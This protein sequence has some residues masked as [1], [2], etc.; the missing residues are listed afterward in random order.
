M[1]KLKNKAAQ[2][3]NEEIVNR[4]KYLI[5]EESLT[6]NQFADYIGIDPSNL[7]KHLNG[8]LPINDSLINKIVVNIGVSKDW[9]K[10]G[11]D[12][13]YS[14]NAGEISPRI[15]VAKDI[16]LS[17]VKGTPVYD[18]DVTAGPLERSSMFTQENLV[19]LINLPSISTDCR[20]VR[21][22]GDSMN[23]VIMNGDLLA[24]KEITNQDLIFWGQIYVLLLE[25][26]RMVKYV[27]KHDD[28]NLVILRSENPN[29]DDMEVSRQ[30]I[31]EMMIVRNIIH[32]ES[33]I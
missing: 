22:S 24:V 3:H 21:V 5:N 9:L 17:N 18:V 11:N 27:R 28:P 23:P 19:G 7:S 26:Y 16:V 20:I 15:T 4:I 6:Q 1:E 14:K 25:D 12:L 30:D 33:R 8:K 13:P 29:Y 31:K 32:I 2:K 10:N